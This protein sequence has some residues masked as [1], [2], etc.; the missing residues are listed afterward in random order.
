MGG[1]FGQ[2]HE[3]D[4][5]KA[6][7]WALLEFEPHQGVRRLV[8][9]LNTLYR[10]LPALHQRDCSPDGFRWIDC[11]DRKNSILALQRL[12][13]DGSF[14]VAV[15]NFTAQPH[16]GY[17]VG[18]PA[19]GRYLEALNS[20]AALYGGQNF[21]NGGAVESEAV[22]AHGFQQSLCLTLPPLAALVFRLG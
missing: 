18:V 13:S 12:A 2:D 22:P 11:E 7:D 21:G 8:R 4:H 14:A 1:E 6:L 20:D 15:L 16:E 3:W 5:N 10:G 19:P 17:R 9:D